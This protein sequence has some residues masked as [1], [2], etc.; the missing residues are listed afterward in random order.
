MQYMN[1]A[2][3]SVQSAVIIQEGRGWR[4]G[5][6]RLII[7]NVKWTNLQSSWFFP[8]LICLSS[9]LRDKCD[10]RGNSYSNM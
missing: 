2:R 7:G 10:M 1:N 5:G 6:F 4:G 9:E 3:V 8:F